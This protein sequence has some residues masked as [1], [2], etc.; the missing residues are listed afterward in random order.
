M[1]CCN[2]VAE[3]FANLEYGP[4]PESAGVAH[5]W[6]AEHGKNFGHFV[7]GEWYKPEGKCSDGCFWLKS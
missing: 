5:A 7:N 3:L 6:M 2:R 4:A 1:S